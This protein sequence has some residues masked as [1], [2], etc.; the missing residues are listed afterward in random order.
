MSRPM[1]RS[2]AAYFGSAVIAGVI[3]A[4]VQF[5][6]DAT[7]P[8]GFL[9]VLVVPGYLPAAVFFPEGFH[10]GSPRGFMALI[11]VFN[12]LIYGVPL[13]LLIRWCRRKNVHD[14]KRF[15]G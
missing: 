7:G 1:L 12:G 4:G 8:L 2:I 10:S 11:S 15:G 14:E 5:G 3:V 6:S 13:F 9:W